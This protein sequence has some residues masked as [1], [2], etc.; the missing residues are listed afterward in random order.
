MFSQALQILRFSESAAY[1]RSFSL[2]SQILQGS[3]FGVEIK[4]GDF[5]CHQAYTE[6]EEGLDVPRQK[7]IQFMWSC[8]SHSNQDT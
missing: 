7:A 8:H 3:G 5:D 1:H 2:H 6:D 4:E